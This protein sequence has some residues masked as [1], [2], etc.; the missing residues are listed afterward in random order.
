VP[1][2]TM[3]SMLRRTS[4][5]RVAMCLAFRTCQRYTPAWRFRKASVY[6]R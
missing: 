2:V 1:H 6:V 3:T 5:G 4:A